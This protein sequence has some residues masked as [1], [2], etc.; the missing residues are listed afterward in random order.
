MVT[1][2]WSFAF[3]SVQTLGKCN[4]DVSLVQ[5][6]IQD[7]NPTI[8]NHITQYK[9]YPVPKDLQ[10]ILTNLFLFSFPYAGDHKKF[11]IYQDKCNYT[12][13]VAMLSDVQGQVWLVVRNIANGQGWEA[14]VAYP[15]LPSLP[16]HCY[17]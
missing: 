13:C 7:G 11:Q 9:S 2:Y 16:W 1:S 17:T 10:S 14:E 8:P 5:S 3:I 15:G 6:E 12:Y 4:K